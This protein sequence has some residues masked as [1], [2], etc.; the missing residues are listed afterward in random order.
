MATSKKVV[1]KGKTKT[2][3]AEAPKGKAKLVSLE[4]LTGLALHRAKQANAKASGKSLPAA[5]GKG[6]AKASGRTPLPTFKA[7]EEFK[8]HF[9]EVTVRTEKDGLLG[10]GIRAI[11]YTG[12]YDP[13]ADDKKKADLKTYDMPTV[14]GIQARLAAVTYGTNMSKRLLPNTLYQIV[15]RVNKKAADGTISVLIKSI[16]QIVKNKKG[17]LAPK[18]LEK[19]DP[20]YR[21]LR[22]AKNFLPAAFKEV[23]MPPKKVRGAAKKNDDA[24]DDE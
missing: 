7:P 12:R 9:V 2:S 17:R 24:E 4:G 10:S 8:P 6:K 13:Q 18:E 15:L 22:K 20:Y 5:K 11:R 3:K 14:I 1:S 23:L 21:K 16:S 19:S